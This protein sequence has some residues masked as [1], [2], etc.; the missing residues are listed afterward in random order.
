MAHKFNFSPKPPPPRPAI[1]KTITITNVVVID[2][3]NISSSQ[4]NSILSPHMPPTI[5]PTA[6]N[7]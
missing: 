2:S 4:P 1:N 5:N 6:I 7:L 3:C